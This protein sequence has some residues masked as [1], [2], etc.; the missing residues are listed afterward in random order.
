M[1]NHHIDIVCT[2]WIDVCKNNGKLLASGGTDA[3]I[4]IYDRRENKIVR[5][6]DNIHTSKTNLMSSWLFAPT[7]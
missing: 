3:D 1:R 4:K 5:T 6:F 2:F 7:L